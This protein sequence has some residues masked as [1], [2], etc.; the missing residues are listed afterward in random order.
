MTCA[1]CVATVERNLKKLD[2]VAS[3]NVNLSS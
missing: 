1:N 3:A 2:G